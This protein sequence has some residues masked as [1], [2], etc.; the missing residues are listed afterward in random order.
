MDGTGSGDR[1]E[2]NENMNRS[3]A[4]CSLR[5]MEE[6]D[7]A[8]AA[9]LERLSFSAPWSEAI[10]R[11][12]LESRLDFLW[13][14]EQ[15][16]GAGESAEQAGEERKTGENR[17]LAGY[18]NLRVIAGEGE[19]MRIAVHPELRGRGLSRKLMDQLE[20]AAREQGAEALTLEV[21]KSNRTAVELYKSYGFR[22][23]AVRKN[24]YENPVEDALIMWL[25]FS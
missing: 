18:C 17:S 4:E 23:E 3:E 8:A 25:Y 24:Y 20:K 1:K 15:A 22:E 2:G 13:V 6:R 19:L 12:S 11:E 10:L 7:L 14:L 16:D 5:S 21:R 9:E